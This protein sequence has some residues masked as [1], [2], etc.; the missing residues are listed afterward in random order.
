VVAALVQTPSAGSTPP[1]AL[2]RSRVVARSISW[3]WIPETPTGQDKDEMPIP[4]RVLEELLAAPQADFVKTRRR[5]ASELQQ[6]GEPFAASE[7]EALKKPTAVVWAVNQL[8]RRHPVRLEQA[9][10]S[11]ARLRDLQ[12]GRAPGDVAA[13]QA[14][15]AEYRR[16]VE[17]L[18]GDAIA[19]LRGDG[20]PASRAIAERIS[21]TLY[22]AIVDEEAWDALRHGRLT[23]E[24]Q[25][26]GFAA[27]AAAPAQ[28]RPRTDRRPP[29]RPGREA[30]VTGL[31]EARRRKAEEQA[32]ARTLEQDAEARRQEAA[33]RARRDAAA[34]EAERR[35]TMA[36][37][38][39]RDL[40]R[41][42][43]RAQREVDEAE[44]ELTRV[45]RPEDR[46]GRSRPET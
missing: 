1:A 11:A 39:V 37:T 16:G 26:A 31:D 34:R 43:E 7:L 8:A 2:S 3:E 19:A 33:E 45:A 12:L 17:A 35:L 20:V 28:A 44:R 23:S 9:A 42:L 5:L 30:S 15:V 24:R 6:K 10:K 38:R 36:R 40:A 21:A 29:P 27:F 22:G 32:R 25:M 4:P 46:P 18:V 14:A 41:E 13:L